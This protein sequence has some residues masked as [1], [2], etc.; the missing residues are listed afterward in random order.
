[1]T[2]RRA[3]VAALS[4]A[5]GAAGTLPAL[6]AHGASAEPASTPGLSDTLSNLPFVSFLPG[7]DTSAASYTT[8]FT[9]DPVRFDVSSADIRLNYRF[10]VEDYYD[11]SNLIWNGGHMAYVT[12]NGR[13]IDSAATV[14]YGNWSVTTAPQQYQVLEL[15]KDFV[16]PVSALQAGDNVLT[17]T[18]QMVSQ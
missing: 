15:G 10:W 14:W 1:M 12:L 7:Q 9:I 8:T 11:P 3:V 18:F 17:F 5:L 6:A 4:F 2:Q 13:R 16:V